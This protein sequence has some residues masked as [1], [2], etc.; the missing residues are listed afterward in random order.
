[1]RRSVHGDLIT[2]ALTAAGL[3]PLSPR[4]WEDLLSQARCSRLLAR[5][6]WRCQ[7]RGW[8][9]GVPAGPRQHLQGALRV[10][11]R[12]RDEV[13]WEADRL[14]WALRRLDTPVVLLK[15]AA[16][17]AA[18]LPPRRGR[19]FADVDL[20]VDRAVL[21]QVEAALFAGGWKPEKL[22]PYD[23]RYYRQWMHELPPMQHVQRLT[24]LDVHHTITPPT[25]R[26][27]VDGRALLLQSV[28][29]PDGSGLRVLAPVDMVLHS[30][31][32][33]MQEGDFAGGLR[34]LLDIHDLLL[35]FGASD[36]RFWS[37]LAERARALGVAVPVSHALHHIERLFGTRPPAGAR[38]A[39]AALR[40][41]G[42][43]AWLMDRLLSVALRPDHPACDTAWTRPARW[44][45]YVRSHALRMPWYQIVPHL[46]RK[47]WMRAAARRQAAAERAELLAREK[48]AR[49]Q[50][51]AASA[52]DG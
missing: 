38:D 17:V 13:L 37:S 1:M 52:A 18:D 11:A 16:Y 3:P 12:Q 49:E 23:Q 14:R 30:A 27:P 35:H 5:L 2:P 26:F 20:M 44:A 46:L 50:R 6:A 45:L 22:D 51:E 7:D 24:Q 29:L 40:P 9:D 19:L 8:M 36:P 15:G 28:P 25:S 10:V 32:H 42:V 4:D 47:A 21:P 48:A 39:V 43:S 34:D 31:V 33:L 41:T